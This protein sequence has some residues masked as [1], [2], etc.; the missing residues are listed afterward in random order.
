MTDSPFYRRVF[1]LLAAAALG[2]LLLKVLAPLDDALGWAAVLAFMLHPLH[3]RLAGGLKGRQGLS[4][5]ILT[6]ATPFVVLAPLSALTVLFVEQ[7]MSLLHYIHAHP[8]IGFPALLVRLKQYPLIGTAMDWMS[9][10]LPSQTLDLHAWFAGA[11]TTLVKS[12]AS[13]GGNVAFSLFGTVV[14]FFMMLFLLFFL[15]RDGER[16]VSQL[17]KLVPLPSER[18][19]P[20]LKYLADVTRAVVYGSTI[21]AIIQG[22]FVAAGFA[23]AGLP[24]PLV[25]G[26]VAM[27]AALL[28]AGAIVVLV[29][30]V[31]YLLIQAH[32][33]AAIFLALWGAG[34]ALVENVVRPLLTAHRA[35]VSTLAVFVGAIGGVSAF[36]ILG[37]VL[38]PVLLSFVVAIVRFLTDGRPASQDVS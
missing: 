6:V 9:R 31:G 26:V 13:V 7:A 30:G 35:N 25:F 37:L 28:P 36:G 14:S 5:G 2:Y 29:P 3:K 16:F 17:V 11:S 38:G 15:L 34:L 32:W 18:R 24:S 4:A 27:I 19:D 8:F 1:A 21:T 12:V 23:L 20:L 22:L 33:G 10:Y